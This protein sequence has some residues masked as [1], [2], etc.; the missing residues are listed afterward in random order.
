MLTLDSLNSISEPRANLRRS[1]WTKLGYFWRRSSCKTPKRPGVRT[2]LL[3]LGPNRVLKRA[4][5][6]ALLSHTLTCYI[7][8]HKSWNI[9]EDSVRKSSKHSLTFTAI[10]MLLLHSIKCDFK[11]FSEK[12]VNSEGRKN[13]GLRM[14]VYLNLTLDSFI[15]SS[16]EFWRRLSSEDFTVFLFVATFVIILWYN[17]KHQ[18]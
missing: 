12:T 6:E 2:P 7:M 14:F 18:K 8:R 5:K 15:T 9:P 17:V 3:F 11:A 1:F 13:L 4:K 10:V 16:M